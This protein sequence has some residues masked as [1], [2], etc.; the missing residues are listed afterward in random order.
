MSTE[1]IEVEQEMEQIREGVALGLWA[2][3]QRPE[4]SQSEKIKIAGLIEKLTRDV[5]FEDEDEF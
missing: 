4:T 2:D 3:Y 5:E 1:V